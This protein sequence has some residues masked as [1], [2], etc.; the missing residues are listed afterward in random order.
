[1]NGSVVKKAGN[2]YVIIEQRD[3]ETGKRRRKWHSGYKTKREAEAARTDMLSRI[4]RGIYVAPSG[5]T[6]GEFLDK[7]LPAKAPTVRPN[8]TDSYRR[9]A[10][11]YIKPR[12]GNVRLRDLKPPILNRLYADLLLSGG[13]GGRALSPKT[14]RNVHV[15]IRKALSDAIRWGLAAVNAADNADPPKLREHGSGAMRTWTAGELARFLTILEEK[16][17]PLHPLYLLAATTGMRRGEVLGLRW[18]DVELEMRTAAVNQ[19]VISVAY[20][21]RFSTPKTKSG[22]RVIALDTT[23]ARVLQ[24]HRVRQ[25]A[26]RLAMGPA[27]TDHDLVFARND[28]EPLHPDFVSQTFDRLVATSGLPRIRLHDLRHTHATLAL[29]A[30]IHPKVVSERLGHSTVSIT[31]DTYSH[32]TP[33]LQSG[34][35]DAVAAMVFSDGR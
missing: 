9:I 21:V 11:S 10:E 30:G 14:V 4:Q 25:A 23:T 26:T 33:A 6:L 28:G 3:P 32:V 17:H 20:Q 7:W 22:R 31:L 18:Q 24:Q 34:V 19:T 13:R 8:T 27:W 29:T 16:A 1:M 15:V 2:W 5:E 12:I 35:A